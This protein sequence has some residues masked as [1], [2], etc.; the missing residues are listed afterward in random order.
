ML[1]VAFCYA[2]I[3]SNLREHNL[4]MSLSA[5]K[6]S[7]H[8]SFM[9][10]EAK[11]M[12]LKKRWWYIYRPKARWCRM[13]MKHATNIAPTNLISSVYIEFE[14]LYF[15]FWLTFPEQL[16]FSTAITYLCKTTHKIS[17]TN[18]HLCPEHI[19]VF[20]RCV[21]QIQVQGNLSR[22][23]R[24]KRISTI[25]Q[26]RLDS[27]GIALLSCLMRW[28]H[29]QSVSEHS[30]KMNIKSITHNELTMEDRMCKDPK[31]AFCNP[32]LNTPTV[33]TQSFEKC[34]GALLD[35]KIKHSVS[36]LTWIYRW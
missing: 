22:W 8:I 20:E 18:A 7:K 4:S 24:D 35:G 16:Q 19:R 36:S 3:T 23:V 26:Q 6:N 30:L 5:P 31:S 32:A 29:V 10:H 2:Y 11:C 15:H 13:Y 14:P 27:P 12:Y 17:A 9:G 33:T 1:R 25:I 21:F 28:I 34:I